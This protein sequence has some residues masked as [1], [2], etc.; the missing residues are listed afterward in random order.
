METCEPRTPEQKSL[1]SEFRKAVLKETEARTPGPFPSPECSPGEQPL[2]Q[3][4]IVVISRGVGEGNGYLCSWGHISAV[5]RKK[6]KSHPVLL[7][8]LTFAIS[9]TGLNSF[10]HVS[11]YRHEALP[12]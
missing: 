9:P 5:K 3:Q 11:F 7:L 12:G 1:E 10:S 8:A 4:I 6:K 2:P